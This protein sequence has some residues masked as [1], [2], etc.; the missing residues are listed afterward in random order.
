MIER[1]LLWYK[2]SQP[3]P[4]RHSWNFLAINEMREIKIIRQNIYDSLK[5]IVEEKPIDKGR[6]ESSDLF[7]ELF[8]LITPIYQIDFS[9]IYQG[10]IKRDRRLQPRINKEGWNNLINKIQCGEFS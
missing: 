5:P 1:Q 10:K 9:E 2:S 4:E 3:F 7:Y 6:I 8:C